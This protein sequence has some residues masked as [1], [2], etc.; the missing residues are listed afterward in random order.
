MKP[1]DDLGMAEFEPNTKTNA[2]PDQTRQSQQDLQK[3]IEKVEEGLKDK[4][5]EMDRLREPLQKA[6]S[7][8]NKALIRGVA[9]GWMVNLNRPMG[10]SPFEN[11]RS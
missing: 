2:F 8:R 6:K 9:E 3:R 7:A 1:G 4:Y 11:H 5:E 10:M